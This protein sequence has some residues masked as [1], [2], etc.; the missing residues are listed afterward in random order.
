MK[1]SEIGEY[2]CMWAK[3]SIRMSWLSNTWQPHTITELTHTPQCAHCSSFHSCHFHATAS[4]TASLFL[5][6]GEHGEQAISSG[7]KARKYQVPPFFHAIDQKRLRCIRQKAGQGYFSRR[8][9]TTISCRNS[10]VKGRMG[11]LSLLD[12]QE[13]AL[14]NEKTASHRHMHTYCLITMYILN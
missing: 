6:A 10:S 12:T 2:I 5:D 13:S 7:S 14:F 3:V 11:E 8:T 4:Q 9:T 1:F